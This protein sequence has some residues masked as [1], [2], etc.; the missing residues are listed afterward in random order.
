MYSYHDDRNQRFSFVPLTTQEP[1][2]EWG[3]SRH[4][5]SGSDWSIW[6]GSLSYDWY[7]VDQNAKDMYIS[8]AADLYGFTS[9]VVNGWNFN[10]KT[11]HLTRDINL[12]GIEWT[13]IGNREHMFHGSFNG[14]GHSIIGL[15]ITQKNDFQGLFGVVQGGSIGNFSVKGSVSGDDHVGGV[16]GWFA[17]GHLYDIYSEVTL[18][19][20]TDQYEGGIAGQN[21]DGKIEFC[22]NHGMVGGGE[23]TELAGGIAG[24]T[25]AGSVIY[26]CYNDGFIYSS[27]DDFVGGISGANNG[28]LVAC[29]INNGKVQGDDH[30]G[31]ILSVSYCLACY[32]GGYVLGDEECGAITGDT[33]G[34]L[35]WC[36]ALAWTNPYLNGTH[37]SNNAEW[38]GAADVIRCLCRASGRVSAQAC[39]AEK[40]G[41]KDPLCCPVDAGAQRC[42]YPDH[43]VRLL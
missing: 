19:T 23:D 34:E 1:L 18:T 41:R 38:I 9:L 27:N 4:D 36:R 2:S 30:V 43:N 39:P 28:G 3:A 17:E 13:P 22:A 20:A 15:L 26:G 16:V 40:A 32:N 8:S 24:E 12:A 14:E 7:F 35:N 11:V 33:A 42:P 37:D 5:C 6:D 10:G 29:C 31:G 25:N 21:F